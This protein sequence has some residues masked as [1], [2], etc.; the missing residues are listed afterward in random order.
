MSKGNAILLFNQKVAGSGLESS[1]VWQCYRE[2][3][4]EDKKSWLKLKSFRSQLT[5]FITI[6]VIYDFCSLNYKDIIT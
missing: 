3:G 1:K 4:L 5:I 2:V 6:K